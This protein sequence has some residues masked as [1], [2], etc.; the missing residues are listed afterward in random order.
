M[1]GTLP[2][3]SDSLSAGKMALEAYQECVSGITHQVIIAPFQ[4]QYIQLSH[5]VI[6]YRYDR[7]QYFDHSCR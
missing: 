7:L 4:A 2:N 5:L 3:S 6:Q 1:E